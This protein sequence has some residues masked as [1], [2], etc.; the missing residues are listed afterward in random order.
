MRQGGK[1]RN[2]IRCQRIELRG[3]KASF[4]RYASGIRDYYEVLKTAYSARVGVNPSI[5]KDMPLM[6]LSGVIMYEV[7]L[8]PPQPHLGQKKDGIK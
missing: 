8:T 3:P 2:K 7:P 6:G 5:L 1:N 4:I